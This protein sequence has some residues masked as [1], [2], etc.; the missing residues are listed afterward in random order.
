LEELAAVL[1]STRRDHG[2]QR[3]NVTRLVAKLLA[4]RAP[5]GTAPLGGADRVD[6]PDEDDEDSDENP[7]AVHELHDRLIEIRRV[8]DDLGAVTSELDVTRGRQEAHRI[9]DDV[10]GEVEQLLDALAT[11]GLRTRHRPRARMKPIGAARSCDCRRCARPWRPGRWPTSKE[12]AATGCA[13]RQT[14]CHLPASRL[15]PPEDSERRGEQDQH[16]RRHE[17]PI[18]RVVRHGGR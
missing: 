17:R 2:L 3:W 5:I 8:L 1:V 16:E 4:P 9:L 18:C 13:H 12:L 15:C 11:P 6:E 10:L 14:R 7:E